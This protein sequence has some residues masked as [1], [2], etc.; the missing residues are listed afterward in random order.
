MAEGQRVIGFFCANAVGDD[1]ELYTDQTR[2]EVLA[3]LHNLRQ[4]GA[5][6]RRPESVPG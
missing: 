2:T 1:I 3:V 6:R 4:Q 5:P